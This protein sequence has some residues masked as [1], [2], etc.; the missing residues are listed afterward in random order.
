MVAGRTV[1][2]DDAVNEGFTGYK[3]HAPK[4]ASKMHGLVLYP[5]CMTPDLRWDT[6][7]STRVTSPLRVAL[8]AIVGVLAVF[9]FQPEA[10]AAPSPSS[11][12]VNA[13][14]LSHTVTVFGIAFFGIAVLAVIMFIVVVLRLRKT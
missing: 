14:Q 10:N 7:W 13:A 4:D 9:A 3:D 6:A 2:S 12:P 1:R 5:E 11:S 8:T